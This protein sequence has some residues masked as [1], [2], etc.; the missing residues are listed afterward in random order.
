MISVYKESD[1]GATKAAVN[2]KEVSARARLQADAAS[3]LE[4]QHV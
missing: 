2:S 1:W 4:A 3:P